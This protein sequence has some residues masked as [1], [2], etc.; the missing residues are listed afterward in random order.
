M[1]TIKLYSKPRTKAQAEA[2]A[3]SLGEPSKMPG[4]AYGISATHC[5]TGAKLA[6]VAGSVCYDCY[7][8]KGHYVQTSVKKGHAKREANL[9]SPEWIDA[10]ILMIGRTGTDYFR[11]HDSGDLQSLGHL[12]AIVRVCEALP[13]VNFWLPTREK[14]IVRQYQR[15]IGA[16]PSNL[17]VRVSG[18]MVD[19]VA[20]AGFAN[21][22]VVVATVGATGHEC[23]APKQDNKCMDCRACWMPS[24]QC[25]TYHKH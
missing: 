16:F 14:A 4:Y 22:S 6:K 7:A 23:P 5:V 24:V 9:A 19:G 2:I 3:G 18:A 25:V 21:V 12:L 20:P 8:M 17:V 1:D 15:A 10:M 11:W 13:S